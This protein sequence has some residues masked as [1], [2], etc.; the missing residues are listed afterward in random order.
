MFGPDRTTGVNTRRRARSLRLLLAMLNQSDGVDDPVSEFRHVAY[1][2]HTTAGRKYV[3]P[4]ELQHDLVKWLVYE[5]SEF[6]HYSLEQAFLAVLARLKTVTP[7]EAALES[8]LPQLAQESLSA[9]STTLKLGRDKRP[10]SSRTLGD[11]L[12]EA[13]ANQQPLAKNVDDPWGE[14]SL[15]PNPPEDAPLTV[16]AR[17]LGCLLSVLARNL[18]PPKPFSFFENLDTEFPKRYRVNLETVRDFVQKNLDTNAAA[19]YT[20]ILSNWVL[21]QHIRVAMRKLRQQTQA[22]FKVAVEEGRYVWIED[23]DPTFTNPRLRQAFRFLRDLGLC[24][25]ATDGWRLR[26]AGKQI[27][28]VPDAK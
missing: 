14:M 26:S 3:A 17:S 2:G 11:L 6:V 20:D 15:L 8:F 4:P 7:K 23:F 27:L 16:L 19:A 22:T 1:F 28:E 13:E 25:G 9:S 21:G 24:G 18:F 5:A 12:R 10:W